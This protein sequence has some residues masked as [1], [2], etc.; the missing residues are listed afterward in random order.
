LAETQKH[1]NEELATIFAEM[2]KAFNKIESTVRESNTRTQQIWTGTEAL[3]VE[4]QGFKNYLPV[5]LVD[6]HGESVEPK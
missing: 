1:N 6:K 5:H 4:I 3:K 2:T